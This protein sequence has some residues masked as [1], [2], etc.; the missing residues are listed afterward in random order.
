MDNS[1]VPPAPFRIRVDG[2][3]DR[4]FGPHPGQRRRV[5]RKR[6]A[7]LRNAR[8]ARKPIGTHWIPNPRP[9]TVRM[10]QYRDKQRAQR[11]ATQERAK[12]ARKAALAVARAAAGLPPAKTQAE[13]QLAYKNRLKA[14]GRIPYSKRE[15]AEQAIRKATEAALYENRVSSDVIN[16]WFAPRMD[17]AT[18]LAYVRGYV[19]PSQP[20]AAERYIADVQEQCRRHILHV[21]RWT[22]ASGGVENARVFRALT[23]MQNAGKYL[24]TSWISAQHLDASR[25]PVDPATRRSIVEA[26]ETLIGNGDVIAREMLL[27]RSLR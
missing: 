24:P 8:K 11:R 20:Q 25:L 13:R 6:L 19:I 5:T 26:S 10:R 14:Q 12:I 7:Q 18:A 17:T 9:E 15:L 4:R 3:P 1:T 27:E 2:Q 22:L 21:N 16:T 23:W